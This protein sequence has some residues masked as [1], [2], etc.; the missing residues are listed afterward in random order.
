MTR[1]VNPIVS[2]I[3]KYPKTSLGVGAGLGFLGIGLANRISDPEEY[4]RRLRANGF[5]AAQSEE[6][7]RIAGG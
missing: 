2:T 5:S 1:A 4:K 3:K 6:M 7:A